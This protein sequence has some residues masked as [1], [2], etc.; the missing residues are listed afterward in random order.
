MY[1]Q[2]GIPALL[3][4]CKDIG[5]VAAEGA[6][7][8]NYASP[9]AMPTWACNKY[10]GVKTI[11]L[12]HGVEGGWHQIA[13]ALGIPKAELDVICAGINHQ[14]WYLSVKHKGKELTGKLR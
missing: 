5:E 12:C 3:S 7:F 14:T 10:G 9:M 8:M 13:E 2:R 6:L 4:F 1:A 11:G